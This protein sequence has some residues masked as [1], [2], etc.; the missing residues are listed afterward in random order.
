MCQWLSVVLSDLDTTQLKVQTPLL[1]Q[2]PNL[3]SQQ[4][5]LLM[6]IMSTSLPSLERHPR[7]HD[8]K[9]SSS[10]SEFSPNCGEIRYPSQNTTSNCFQMVKCHP[11]VTPLTQSTKPHANDAVLAVLESL[12]HFCAISAVSRSRRGA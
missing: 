1:L 4:C 12:Q 5:S 8:Y 6:L 11:L 9:L 2:E 10:P 3:D 7:I